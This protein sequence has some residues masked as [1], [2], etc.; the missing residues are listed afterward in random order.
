M[1][2]FPASPSTGTVFSAA[3]ASWRYDGTKWVAYTTG[4]N[5]GP[6]DVGRNLIHNPLFNIAQ[7]GAGPFTAS[8]YTLDRWYGFINLDTA[9]I[10]QLGLAPGF[11]IDEAAAFALSTVFTGNAGAAAQTVLIQYMEDVRRWQDSDTLYA[12]A[13]PEHKIGVSIDKFR[14]SASATVNGAGQAISTVFARYVVTFT[15]SSITGKRWEPM[16]TI[17]RL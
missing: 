14:R 15:A 12:L 1:I 2:D 6:N 16:A 10:T 7:R 4:V 5:G 9:S 8:G 13:Y 11:A 3:G 17:L